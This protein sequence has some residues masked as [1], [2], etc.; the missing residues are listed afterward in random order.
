[1]LKLLCILLFALNFTLL[2]AQE[3][4]L[5]SGRI[6]DKNGPVSFAQ[7]YT[8]NRT[9]GAVADEE[10][11][12]SFTLASGTYVLNVR[13]QGYRLF[14]KE[15]VVQSSLVTDLVFELQPDALGLDE[16][17]MSASRNRV[18]KRSAPVVVSTLKENLFEAVQSTSLS[19]VLG[20]A[21]GVRVETNCQNCGFTQ[22]R[23]NGLEGPYTQILLN[24]KPVFTSLIAVYGLEQIPTNT[25]ERVEIVRSGGSALY[26]SNA[27]A[28]TINIIT[29][30][31]IR[32]AW[33]VNSNLSIING[34]T[35]DRLLSASTSLVAD[36]LKSGISVFGNYRKRDSFDANGDGFTEL[37]ELTNNT[38]GTKLFV[39]PSDY[40]KLTV[41]ATAIKEYR[42]GGDRLN[43]A[44]QFTD[45]T[46]ELDHN[47]FFGG[48][49]AEIHNKAY[50]QKLD[51]YSSTSFTNRDSYYGGLGGGRTAQDSITANNAFGTT[52][53]L[54]WISGAQHW[55][56]F[57]SGNQLTS[58]LEYN[59]NTTE[60]AIPG[61]NRLIDQ[62]VQSLGL[63]TQYEHPIGEKVNLLAGARLDRI[64]VEGT[65]QVGELSRQIDRPLW[66]LSPRITLAYQ[67][68]NQLKFRG[69]YARGFRAPQAFNEDIH[70]SS[71]G[72]EPQF[73]LLSE[74][75]QTEYSDAFT[76]S[77]NFTS[78]QNLRQWDLLLEGFLT[79][80]SNPFTTVSTGATLPNGSILEEVRN[81]EGAQVYGSNFEAGYSPNP[82]WIIQ[83]GGTW[84]NS[85]YDRP[86]ALFEPENGSTEEAVFIDQFV[87][88]PNLYGYFNSSWKPSDKFNAD[89]T[90]QYTGPMDVPRVINE[91]GQIELNRSRA[92]LDLNL[93]MET[94]FHLMEE[95]QVTF[96][97][98]VKN[99]FNSYQ[100]DFETGPLRDSDYIYGPASPRM[101][102]I[103]LK[104]GQFD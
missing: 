37:V 31:P 5:I 104:I 71:V 26:G 87:R 32:N 90:A 82:D 53:D 67:V 30:D 47:T 101:F 16:V 36:N 45:I 62:T 95:F 96:S 48:L 73:V 75:L 27:I 74:N 88:V 99:L 91:E 12:F 52:K 1:M 64:D 86:Q 59:L 79:N 93:K 43:L 57:K 6:V 2:S 54:A 100:N 78:A 11:Y 103:G 3:D 23:L 72:G 83:L 15:L 94:H 61:Y 68:M 33:E 51:I 28:G 25:I 8:S 69:G 19:D 38:F 34:N 92:F 10:G 58:G 56:K 46:E 21:P 20:F 35:L 9:V 4:T 44:P 17:V 65:Y 39:R 18:E 55:V 102:F 77:L 98:G 97:G 41:D 84:Q 29:K 13:A 49:Q 70:I 22:V 89:L 76:A 85:R 40:F 60:D 50:T 81:G 7:L 42:R 80:L 14:S 66:A 63:Y 24:N